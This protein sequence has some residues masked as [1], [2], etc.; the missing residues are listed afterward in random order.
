MNN[1]H[2]KLQMTKQDLIFVYNQLLGSIIPK[3]ETH[4]PQKDHIRDEVLDL[5]HDFLIEVFEDAKHAMVVDGIDLNKSNTSIQDVLS[6]KPREKTE[7]FNIEE[8]DKL[9]NILKSFEEETIEVTRLRKKIPQDISDVFDSI[10][11]DTDA[12]VTQ[13][14]NELDNE[15]KTEDANQDEVQDHNADIGKE[16]GQVGDQDE[17]KDNNENVTQEDTKAQMINDY[18]QHLIKLLE[19]K[20]QIPKQLSE[21]DRLNEITVFL[22]NK[23]ENDYV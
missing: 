20:E 9:R 18:E 22:Q 15:D 11:N 5:L 10:I 21:I 3:I 16:E 1:G 23:Y 19:L 14:L 2:E 17:N 4:L 6:I 7:P 13:I 12:E 8:N